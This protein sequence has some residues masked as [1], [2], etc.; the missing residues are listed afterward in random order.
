MANRSRADF[1]WNRFARYAKTGWLTACLMMTG[2]MM[3]AGLAGAADINSKDFSADDLFQLKKIWTVDLVVAPAEWKAMTPRMD[4]PHGPSALIGPEGGRNGYLAAQGLV[5]DWAHADFSIDG[6]SFK[7][8]GLRYK[9][10]GTF[11]Q[12]RNKISMKLNLTKYQKGQKLAG[13]SMLNLANNITDAGWMNEELA[14]KLFR[15]AGAPSPRSSYAKVYVTIPGQMERRYMG[16]YS[17][18]EEVDDTFVQTRFGSKGGALMKPV[19]LSLFTD[20]GDNWKAYNQ[21]YDPK[22]EITDAHKAR[23]FEFCKIVTKG[24]DEEFAA[25]LPEYI[26]LDNLARFVAV[27]VY[28]SDFDGFLNNGQNYY[29]YLDPKTNKF[30][31]MAWDQDHG[32]GQMG[33]ASNPQTENFSIY[34][35]WSSRNRFLARVF[36]V[37]AFKDLYLARMR[38]FSKTIFEPARLFAEVDDLA[39][40]LRPAI[41]EESKVAAKFFDMAVADPAVADPAAVP[42]AAGPQQM[43]GE[44]L[45]TFVKARTPKIIDQLDGKSQ[46]DQVEISTRA[47]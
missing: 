21:I 30:N 1:C 7:D 4:G 17:L 25:K 11:A 37:P 41:E 42:A 19:A 20:L 14:Y 8:V 34:H 26:N 33:R 36:A 3:A 40:V 6:K 35:P 32:F 47:N 31:F 28:L 18:I 9:G 39:P 44:R 2:L 43:F 5:F 15:D 12:G 27:D 13:M 10:N 22:T 16:L 46:G 24:S 23:F 38:E 45:K 29:M